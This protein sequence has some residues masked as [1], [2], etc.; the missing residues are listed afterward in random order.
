M[1]TAAFQDTL[2][3]Q[4]GPGIAFYSAVM[5]SPPTT[6]PSDSTTDV[7][8]FRKIV[9]DADRTESTDS[10][11]GSWLFDTLQSLLDRDPQL[12]ELGLLLPSSS[13]SSVAHAPPSPSVLVPSLPSSLSSSLPPHTSGPAFVLRLDEHAVGIAFWAVPPLFHHASAS[14]RHLRGRPSSLTDLSA[15]AVA[16]VHVTRALLLIN[17]DNLTAWNTRKHLLLLLPLPSQSSPSPL[18]LSSELSFLSLVFSKHPKS[19]EAWSHRRW[20]LTQLLALPSADRCAAIREELRVVTAS[21]ERYPKNYHAWSHRL[22][23][24][25]LMEAQQA[26][27]QE[28]KDGEDAL[29]SEELASITEWNESHVSD[30]SGF[31]YRSLL[32]SRLMARAPQLASAVLVEERS[33]L[34]QLQAMYRGHQ[35][36]W[37]YRR[38]LLHHLV[39]SS[40]LHELD[41]VAAVERRWVVEQASDEMASGWGSPED[42]RL[43]RLYSRVHLLYVTELLVRKR[44]Q[45]RSAGEG[46]VTDALACMQPPERQRWLDDLQS[47]QQLSD[48]QC[49]ADRRLAVLCHP[50]LAFS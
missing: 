14:F 25:G 12:C 23:V 5:D 11:L 19:S 48:K 9:E 43:E 46:T 15:S 29:L 18:S 49:W 3:R 7:A 32:L 34:S 6:E 13:P 10:R 36:L 20:V 42:E 44:H 40:A 24:L 27:G 38:F 50:P 37:S 2:W 26:E 41:E 22:A 16:L 21:A 17:A 1:I 30:H 33:F 39:R 45:E 28:G 35:T 8:L 47:V 31:H 4:C